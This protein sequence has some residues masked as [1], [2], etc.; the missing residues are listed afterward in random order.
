[1]KLSL[2]PGST[3]VIL[4]VFI[5]DTSSD[6]GAGLGSLNESSSIVGGYVRAGSTGLALAVDQNVT[7]EGTYEAPTTDNQVRIGT[8]ANMRTGTYELHFHND[9]FAASAD[10]VVITLG[11][12]TNMAD[13]PIEIQL[14]AEVAVIEMA[15]SVIDNASLAADVGS[16]AYATNI[17]ALAVRKVL[18]ELKLDHLVAVADSDD[19]VDDSIL[20]KMA[21]TAGDWSDF[22]ETTDSL[23][24][25]RDRDST[26]ALTTA[27]SDWASATTTVFRLDA[28]STSDDAYI[29]M[30]VAVT[31]ATDG[32][33]EVRRISDYDGSDK[34]IT[35]RTA[36]TFTP[37]DNDVVEISK[38][39]Y[40]GVENETAGAGAYSWAFTI[41]DT[42]SNAIE[43][44]NV[45]IS[46]S[47]SGSPVYR[48]G[49]SS[50]S[51]GQAAVWLD[52]G[53]WYVFATGAGHMYSLDGTDNAVTLAAGSSSTQYFDIGTPLTGFTDSE[54]NS[55]TSHADSF[56]YRSIQEIRRQVD[57]PSLNSKYTDAVL[58]D[59]MTQAYSEILSELQRDAN[60]QLVMTSSHTVVAD[61]DTYILPSTVGRVVSVYIQNDEGNPKVFLGRD[62][63][64]SAYGSPVMIEE[65]QV[66]VDLSYVSTGDI[67]KVDYIPQ[68]CAKLF[69]GEPDSYT[70][71]TMVSE[72]AARTGNIDT[73]LNAYAGYMIRILPESVGQVEQQRIVASSTIAAGKVTFTVENAWSP[74]LSGDA[75]GIT[76]EVCPPF[77][78]NLDQ[79][80]ASRVGLRI[81]GNEGSLKRQRA[82]SLEYQAQMR[83]LRLIYATKDGYRGG[84]TDR[85]GVR[86]RRHGRINYK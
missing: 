86:R 33:I 10:Y 40:G 25:I 38:E 21:A 60:V 35:V 65:N 48:G 5:Q 30:A 84:V 58:I 46:A 81:S 77:G 9:L 64:L 59:Y 41:R 16:T 75:S 85:N 73:R 39:T 63:K 72:T 74:A 22:S 31:D 4:T 19:P 17:I 23:Q 32:M 68:G 20:A 27:V 83:T 61:Q 47:S 28:G 42:S 36:F 57:E 6:T 37:A 45:W 14:G 62:S 55:V 79:V 29:N 34:E 50:N 44:A 52:Y 54:G 43:G 82:I 1:M 66:R 2:K 67:L 7:T 13:L 56:I 24:S 3:S 71:L 18:D 8:P 12:A 15:A 69:E 11:G 70:T 26:F 53:T 51:L 78:E 80:I 49:L 76:Y